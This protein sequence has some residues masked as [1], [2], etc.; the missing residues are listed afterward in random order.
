MA[1]PR[2]GADEPAF[3]AYVRLVSNGP[4]L[5]PSVATTSKN[6][7]LAPV[8]SIGRADVSSAVSSSPS[9]DAALCCGEPL[10]QPA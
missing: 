10:R 7:F 1:E 9:S 2:G 8:R 5:R 3:A 4:I 6:A